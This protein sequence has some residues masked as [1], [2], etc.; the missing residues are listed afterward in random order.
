ML[1]PGM[2]SEVAAVVGA[3]VPEMQEIGLEKFGASVY[4]PRLETDGWSHARVEFLGTTVWDSE[5]DEG[6]LT[7]DD[8]AQRMSVMCSQVAEVGTRLDGL[9]DEANG[10]GE[11]IA[12]TMA[13]QP[14]SET[15]ATFPRESP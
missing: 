8:L 10:K 7:A 1:T 3:V 12:E 5:E 4:V 2:L 13:R 15:V 9:L 14:R 11:N 6:T